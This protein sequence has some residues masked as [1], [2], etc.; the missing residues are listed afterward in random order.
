[1]SA[2]LT[3]SST[4]LRVGGLDANVYGRDISA[5]CIFVSSLGL[6]MLCLI[7][8]NHIHHTTLETLN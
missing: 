8:N 5:I 7:S 2:K 1:M 3:S 6:P 4:Q